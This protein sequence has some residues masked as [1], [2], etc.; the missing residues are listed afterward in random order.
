[1]QTGEESAPVDPLVGA[2]KEWAEFLAWAE[3]ELAEVPASVPLPDQPRMAEDRWKVIHLAERLPQ[4]EVKCDWDAAPASAEALASVGPFRSDPPETAATGTRMHRL[5]IAGF[6]L[7]R[8]Q[9]GCLVLEIRQTRGACFD[10]VWSRAGRLR[11][12]VPDNEHFHTLR[13]TTDGLAEWV[14]PLHE[15]RIEVEAAADCVI[16]IRAVRFLSREDSFPRGVGVRRLSLDRQAR[17]ALYLHSPAEVRFAG[18]VVPPRGR[19]QAGLALVGGETT[20][21]NGGDSQSEP[22][23]ADP[24]VGRY[25][26]PTDGAAAPQ[27][28]SEDAAA[29]FELL[30]D[31]AGRQTR[32]LDERAEAPD[33]WREVGASLEPWAGKTVALILR[34]EADHPGLVGC[35][36]D[37][38]VYEPVENPPRALIYLID[39]LGA[40]H[41]DLYGYHRPTMPHLRELAGRG[42]CFLQARSNSP[43]TVESVADLM[44]SMPTERHGV[45]H[46]SATAAVELVTLAEALRAA[47]F[48]TASF[49]TNVN[50][51]PRQGMDQG[52]DAFFDRIGYWWTGQVDRTVPIEDVVGWLAAHRDRPTF[53]YVHTAEP[54]A[55]YTPPE[56]LADRFDS[57]YDGP[58]DGT[59]HG[60]HGFRKARSRRDLR[61][62]VALYDAEVAYA[63]ERLGAFWDALAAAGL[64]EGLNLFVTADHGEAFREHGTWEHGENL[65]EELLRIP[66]VA[67]GPAVTA[68]GLCEVPVQLHDLMPTLLDLYGVPQPYPLTG[69]SLRPLLAAEG[70]GGDGAASTL[71]EALEQRYVFASNHNFRSTGVIEHAVLAEGRWKLM[72]KRRVGTGRD[73]GHGR[74]LLFD[75]ANDAVEKENIIDE[76]QELA[77]RLIG[78]LLERR[79][80]QAPFGG[81]SQEE[82]IEMS[83]EQLEQL[84]SLGYV[85]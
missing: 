31:E 69:R 75:L 58:F 33:R 84:R 36:G 74:F 85:E 9:V 37:P 82:P 59:Y 66:L 27:G 77:R 52:F 61:H 68:R 6:D 12:P 78:R 80:A 40:K 15:L 65:Y 72:Y 71:R 39:A 44:L 50:A 8:E 76:Q 30:V 70:N 10:L 3:R 41:I 38:V 19:F 11:V 46:P 34:I 16:E 5:H 21:T 23:P 83:P 32:V 17:E 20:A 56:A 51:G 79:R 18:V 26:Q 64:A 48:A 22:K 45:W 28:A 24:Q 81:D 60:K 13:L 54:H 47:G 35:W 1:L 73:R 63:D 25:G 55:P 49:C 14:G 42:I 2:P 57:D 67:T 4:A 62:V 43:L 29:R 7:H 53:V